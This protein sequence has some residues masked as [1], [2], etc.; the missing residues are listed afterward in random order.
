M[1]SMDQRLQKNK[2]NYSLKSKPK[3]SMNLQL[4]KFSFEFAFLHNASNLKIWNKFILC[5]KS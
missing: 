2:K 1:K 3:D 4:C 5:T